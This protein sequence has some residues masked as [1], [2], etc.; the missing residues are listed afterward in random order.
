MRS[1]VL[2]RVWRLF[3]EGGVE[4]PNCAQRE[5]TLRDTPALRALIAALREG[6]RAGTAGLIAPGAVNAAN[7]LPGKSIDSAVSVLTR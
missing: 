1:D 5:I 7:A 6:G 2:K 3:Q 4:L